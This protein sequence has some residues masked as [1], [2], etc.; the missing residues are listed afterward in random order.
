MRLLRT[1]T[2][3]DFYFTNLVVARDGSTALIFDYNMLGKGYVYSDI[4]NVCGHLGNEEA[5]AAFLSAY[6]G[7]NENEVIVDNVVNLINGLHIACLRKNFPDWVN[8]LLD[9]VRDGKLSEAV[10]KLLEGKNHENNRV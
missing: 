10:E 3:N 4:R 1:L 6:G 5:R 2:Y 7:Y 8:E 9:M